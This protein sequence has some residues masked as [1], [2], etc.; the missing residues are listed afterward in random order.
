MFQG[1]TV[2]NLHSRQRRKWSKVDGG[3]KTEFDESAIF[4][5]DEH[6]QITGVPR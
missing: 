2:L 5:E 6:C 1:L 3:Y 4:T